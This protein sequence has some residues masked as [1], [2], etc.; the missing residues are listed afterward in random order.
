MCSRTAP[1]LG[2]LRYGRGLNA[3]TTL[4]GTLS[5]TPSGSDNNGFDM[6]RTVGLSLWGAYSESGQ[7]GTGWQA[8]ASVGRNTGTA[9]I[10]RGRSL[11]NVIVSTG[12]ADVT[13]NSMQATLGYGVQ[14]QDWLFTPSATL[15]RY[16]T[17]RDAYSES[18]GDFNA[19]Y[20]SLSVS[21]TTLDL[22][23]AA[24]YRVSDTGTL[25]LEAGVVMEI[26][27]GAITLTGTSVMP[28]MT[29]VSMDGGL[30]R[31]ET[32]GFASIGYR[33]ELNDS[34][35]ITGALRAG[36]SLF[37]NQPQVHVGVGFATEF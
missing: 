15:T 19:A 22:Q 28:G 37:G 25:M 12:S 32:H 36:Q 27:V 29:A 1:M 18:G 35:S 4:G 8:S 23:L 7:L 26:N 33:H 13:T 34:S 2:R 9:D 14:Q 6:G 30:E 31:N 5:I 3:E 24:D 17:T 16:T 10:S 20:D 21:S 11:D